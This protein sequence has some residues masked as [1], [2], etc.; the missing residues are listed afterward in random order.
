MS[1]LAP[2]SAPTG[3]SLDQELIDRCGERAR[4]KVSDTDAT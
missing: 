3:Y 1:A 2:N 4:C